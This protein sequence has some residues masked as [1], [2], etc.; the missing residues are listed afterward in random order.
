MLGRRSRGITDSPQARC[1]ARLRVRGSVAGVLEQIVDYRDWI[2]WVVPIWFVAALGL[3]LRRIPWLGL[4]IVGAFAGYVFVSIAP[5]VGRNAEQFGANV[6]VGLIGGALIGALIGAILRSEASTT[7]EPQRNRSMTVIG[8]A[9][10]SG[11]AGALILGF[12]VALAREIPPD[13]DLIT[14]GAAFTGG[15][16]GWVVGA[17]VSWHATRGTG[18]PG[19]SDRSILLSAVLPIAILGVMLA[20]SVRS[21]EFGP[22]IDDIGPRN[23]L[24]GP[25]GALVWID[26]A[27]GII[28]VLVVALR[29]ASTGRREGLCSMVRDPGTA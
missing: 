9:V 27:I 28:T 13:L 7:S 10:A 8:V 17:L 24:L 4:A 11:A 1:F 19:W 12:G 3:V 20:S 5:P 26:T 22:M 23:R 16:V 2:G 14:M 15:G 25:L 6:A 21:A 29:R 18:P